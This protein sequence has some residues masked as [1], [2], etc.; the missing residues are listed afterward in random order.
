MATT[1]APKFDLAALQARISAQFK[2]L[3][4]NDPADGA[5][6]SGDGYTHLEKYLNGI[7]R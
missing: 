6:D 5:K 1:A 7:R 4:P 2:G 3:N